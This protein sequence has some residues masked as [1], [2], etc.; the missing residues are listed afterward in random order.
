MLEVVKKGQAK[1]VEM[2]VIE[3]VDTIKVAV[4]GSLPLMDYVSEDGIPAGFTKEG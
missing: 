2:P 1:P 4:T 3:D